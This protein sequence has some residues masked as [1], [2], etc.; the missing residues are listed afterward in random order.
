MVDRLTEIGVLV[1]T[2]LSRR[3]AN[4]RRAGLVLGEF[5]GQIQAG[6]DPELLM[7]FAVLYLQAGELQ[8]L[9]QGLA[10]SRDG[11]EDQQPDDGVFDGFEI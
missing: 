6:S 10:P 9:E 4:Q 2:Q 8:I 5:G 7:E 3:I 1:V 11:K